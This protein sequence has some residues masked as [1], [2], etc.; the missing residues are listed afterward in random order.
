MAL[1]DK[2][3]V[4]AL[5]L[6]SGCVTFDERACPREREYSRAELQELAKQYELSPPAIKQAMIDYQKLR[7]KARACRGV[8]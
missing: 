6:L 7:D 8:R 1:F 3:P 2:A 4:I 5:L